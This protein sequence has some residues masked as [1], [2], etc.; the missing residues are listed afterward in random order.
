[1]SLD[2]AFDD[3]TGCKWRLAGHLVGSAAYK[4]EQKSSHVNGLIEM[5]S[6]LLDH[7]WQDYC[8]QSMF[9]SSG[10]KN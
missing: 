9:H 5:C 8:T 4:V 10:E 3:V 6:Y 1:M 2:G 7:R